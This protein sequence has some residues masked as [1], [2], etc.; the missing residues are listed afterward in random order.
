MINFFV[1]TMVVS[2]KLRRRTIWTHNPLYRNFAKAGMFSGSIQDDGVVRNKVSIYNE[3]SLRYGEYCTSINVGP[4]RVRVQCRYQD[5][6]KG[7][8]TV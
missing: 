7:A 2:V 3:M 1:I 5:M 8:V 4:Y 6:G